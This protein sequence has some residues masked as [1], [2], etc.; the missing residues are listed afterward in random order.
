MGCEI[1]SLKQR[2]PYFTGENHLMMLMM[3]FSISLP[4]A[5]IHFRA[6]DTT[7]RNERFGRFSERLNESSDVG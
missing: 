5:L 4:H 6:N 2:S 7:V 1:K 3:N